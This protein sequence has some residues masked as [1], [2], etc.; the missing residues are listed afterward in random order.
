MPV[1]DFIHAQNI[2]HRDIKPDNIILRMSDQLPVLIDF[3]AVKESMATEVT[4]SG[5]A[6]TSIVIGTPGF[7]PSEQ[8]VGRPVYSSDLYSLGLTAIYLLTGKSPQ[9]LETDMRTGQIIWR[10]HAPQI[11]PTLAKVLDQSIEYHPRD[12]YSSAQEMLAV[13]GQPLTPGISTI[14]SPPSKPIENLP[15]SSAAEKT[16]QNT[17][18]KS[19]IIGVFAIIAL[20]IARP[21]RWL[22]PQ[23]SPQQP[24]A[25]SNPANQIPG[26]PW[27]EGINAAMN[28]ATLAQ[29]AQSQAEWNAVASEW[30]KASELMNQVAESNPN[31]QAAVERTQQYANNQRI[32]RQRSTEFNSASE[33]VKTPNLPNTSHRDSSREYSSQQSDQQIYQVANVDIDDTLYVLASADVSDQIIGCLPPDGTDILKIGDPVRVKDGGVWLPIQY[34]GIRG[35]V[36]S[37]YLSKQFQT[38]RTKP[39]DSSSFRSS[40]ARYRISNVDSDDVLYILYGPGVKHKI[41]GCIPYQGRNISLIGDSVKVEDGGVWIPINYQEIVGWVN[42]YYLVRE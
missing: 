17:A 28:A 1:L 21:T 39:S 8:A 40:N 33:A 38:S 2:V 27:R 34:K 32:A 11:S 42:S 31:Y 9:E 22:S 36:N 25:Q 29:T 30:Q 16:P 5:N 7:M 3:G 13:L 18:I 12:R 15:Q 6:T 4:I 37:Y 20:S 35:W 10:S 24:L 41:V 19:V 14:V 23:L 26:D